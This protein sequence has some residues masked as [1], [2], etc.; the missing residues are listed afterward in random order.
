MGQRGAPWARGGLRR[1]LGLV[2][3]RVD[4]AL[5]LVRLRPFGRAVVRRERL[6]APRGRV[7]GIGQPFAARSVTIR[8]PQPLDVDAA[9][10]QGIARLLRRLERVRQRR[11]VTAMLAA[12]RHRQRADEPQ[13][14]E[15]PRPP[16]QQRGVRHS[17][18]ADGGEDGAR[19]R[20]RRWPIFGGHLKRLRTDKA[21]V[22]RAPPPARV[23]G[24]QPLEERRPVCRASLQWGDCSYRS[25]PATNPLQL[26][27]DHE[28][29]RPARLILN[30]R[31]S[32]ING[33]T[34]GMSRAG[35]VG[36]LPGLQRVAP[37]SDAAFCP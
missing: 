25:S 20:P 10:P 7:E 6:C 15:P 3:C 32:D 18:R 37:A 30:W 35:A 26:P 8:H 22:N 31:P 24:H 5:L 36:D 23:R 14:C 11:K 2:I 27:V 9:V 12:R 29:R 34:P 28:R 19:L 13:S 21:F 4:A 33:Y 1:H 17:P 16:E